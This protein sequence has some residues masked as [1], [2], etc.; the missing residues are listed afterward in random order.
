[1]KKTERRCILCNGKL[2]DAHP[3]YLIQDDTQEIHGPL[4]PTCAARARVEGQKVWNLFKKRATKY[5]SLYARQ[6]HASELDE[7]GSRG[8]W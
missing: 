8:E 2:S 4:H 5:G 6:I 3:V 1:V 7:P